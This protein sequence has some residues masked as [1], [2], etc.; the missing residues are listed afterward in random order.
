MSKNKNR[1]IEFL[2]GTVKYNAIKRFDEGIVKIPSY[3]IAEVISKKA[4]LKIYHQKKFLVSYTWDNIF[5]FIKK[6]EKRVYHGKFRDS[7]IDY[8]LNQVKT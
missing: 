5:N 3:V 4:T 2:P 7:D 8:Q 6:I 1:N